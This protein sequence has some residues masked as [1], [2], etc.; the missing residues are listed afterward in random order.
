MAEIFDPTD[1]SWTGAPDMSAARRA[2]S[3]TLLPDGRVLVVGGYGE[4]NE[5][6]SSAE[7]YD[8]DG[9]T[10]S[11]AGTLQHP[12]ADHTATLLADGTVLV[13]GGLG[14]FTLTESYDPSSGAWTPRAELS[15][16]R[17]LHSAQLLANGTLMVTGGLEGAVDPRRSDTVEIYDP[18][19]DAWT[20][21]SQGP[22]QPESAEE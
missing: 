16:A 4:D 18:K 9:G 8:P 20:A 11:P 19:A 10:W 3:A 12:R 2:H 13:A 22:V 1:G 15:T 6:L 14:E 7:I 17:Y 21:G 5:P